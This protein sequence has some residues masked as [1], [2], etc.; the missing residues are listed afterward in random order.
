MDIIASDKNENGE[1]DDLTRLNLA[2]HS[3]ITIIES[4]TD[5]DEIGIISFN[6]L[7]HTNLKMTKNE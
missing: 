7:A 5:N 2:C 1:C 6:H 3:I 4:L